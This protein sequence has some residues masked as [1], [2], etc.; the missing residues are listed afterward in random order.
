MIENLSQIIILPE[1]FDDCENVIDSSLRHNDLL[2]QN[3][4]Q[5]DCEDYALNFSILNKLQIID[6]N[7]SDDSKILS[8]FKS[9]KSSNSL[10]DCHFL[11]Q[12][13][14]STG[15]ASNGGNIMKNDNEYEN[16]DT[17]YI[18][19]C[20]ESKISR[21]GVNNNLFQLNYETTLE[22]IG[23]TYFVAIKSNDFKQFNILLEIM[24][25]FLTQYENSFNLN[26]IWNYSSNEMVKNGY[27]NW[28]PRKCKNCYYT[29]IQLYDMV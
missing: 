6:G 26:S 14:E 4:P 18:K 2:K 21:Y 5:N 10:N 23:D 17:K 16:F 28:S 29:C 1:N 27:K 20:F 11:N 7:S 19:N 13:F 22:K 25:K 12:N 3:L 9:E 24:A 15:K 8:Q